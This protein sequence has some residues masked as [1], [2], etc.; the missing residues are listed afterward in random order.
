MKTYTKDKEMPPKKHV[1]G[2]R[3]VLSF[4]LY[5]FLFLTVV[6]LI[7]G[8][9]LVVYIDK[10]VE[11]HIDETMFT[12]V[13][14]DSATLYYYEAAAEGERAVEIPN[15]ALYGGYRCIYA[16][17]DSIPQTLIDAFVSIED[18]RFFEHHGVDWKRTISAGFNYFLKFSGSYGGSTITQQLIKNVTDRDDY[19]FQ[20][21]IQEIFWAIDL[22]TKMDK[23]EILEL[24]LNIINLSQGCYGVRTAANYYYSKELSALTLAECATIAAITNSPSY[25]DPLRNPDHNKVRRD[26]ILRQMYEQGYI[27]EGECEEALMT[28]ISLS[29]NEE[30]RENTVNSWYVDM[31]VEDVIEDLMTQKGY[32]RTMAGL[33]VYTG[34]LKIYTAMDAE[35]QRML[36]DYYADST[37]FYASGAEENPQSAMIVIDPNTGDILGVAGAIGKKS[38]NRIQNFATQTVRPAGSVIK[39]LSVY[40]PAL[41]NGTITWGSVYDDV[42][43]N[44]GKYNLDPKKGAIVEPVAWPQNSNR[45]YRGLT[46]INYAMAHSVNTV[47]LRVLEDI[48]CD[49]AFDFLYQ[50][51]HMTSLIESRTLSGGTTLSDK[52]YAALGL[53]QFNYGVTLLE[54]TAAYS[55]FSSQGVYHHPRSYYRVS[56]PHGSVILEKSYRGEAVISEANADIMTRMLANV[57][58]SGTA[59]EITLDDRVACAGKTGTTQNNCDRWYIGYT[60]YFIGG[61]WYGYEYPRSMT[62]NNRCIGIWDEVMTLL[63]EK[64]TQGVPAEEVLEFSHSE[65]VIEAEYCADS[66]LLMTEACR[67]DP[68]GNRKCM[69]YFVKG[70]EPSAYCDCHRLVAYDKL[71]GG[72]SLNGDCPTEKT[73]LVGMI[74]VERSFPTQIYVTDAEYVYREIPA[75]VLPETSV[76]LPFFSNMLKANEYCGI[77]K[78]TQQYNRLCRGHFRYS[79]WKKKQES[80]TEDS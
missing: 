68:R 33:T 7:A 46:D 38:G 27:T 9:V 59:K 37:N 51:L 28:E 71:Y 48:G 72:I 31:V 24:Y 16:S 5:V 30:M 74:T 3:S 4:V 12:G 52:D 55:I 40:G 50:R 20:R 34:G 6:L 77:S 18:K 21:K 45:V 58:K 57:V 79:E 64:Y 78:T 1:G 65:E 76:S 15:A 73:T 22:E 66:G 13:G 35:V 8:M 11:K 17:Y 54:T 63:H 42:P 25:Y 69:G 75:D 43:L 60:P 41:E 62:G 53:G 2:F 70:T 39:P 80:L 29:V 19:S 10:N 67:R 23:E 49:T 36:E 14:A 44:F 32:S 56:D 26:L 47:T 61:V